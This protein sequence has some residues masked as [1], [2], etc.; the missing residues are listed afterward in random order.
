MEKYQTLLADRL[1]R[2]EKSKDINERVG[3]IT[4]IVTSTARECAPKMKQKPKNCKK[5]WCPE[6]AK[7]SK[8]SKRAFGDWKKGGCPAEPHCELVLAKTSAKKKLRNRQR[9]IHAENRTK[10]YKE[11]TTAHT[12]NKNLFYKLINR[13]RQ[14]GREILNELVIN[15]DHLTE[16]DSIRQ[17]WADYFKTLATPVENK[18][19]D[20]EY[21]AHIELRKHLIQNVCENDKNKT[22][23][24]TSDVQ[25]VINSMKNSKA[26]DKE[27]C[28]TF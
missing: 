28:R 11:I 6:L 19:F 14:T 22:E 5:F 16:S 26:A 12:E 2:V 17:G 9:Q 3:Q 8:D 7:L 24:S 15:G 4:D 23:I 20:E 27:G 13:Q 1:Q 25:K 10:M 18:N 21:K